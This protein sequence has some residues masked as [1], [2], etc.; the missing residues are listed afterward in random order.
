MPHGQCSRRF[1]DDCGS[2]KFPFKNSNDPLITGCRCQVCCAQLALDQDKCHVVLNKYLRSKTLPDAYVSRF[3]RCAPS[4]PGTRVTVGPIIGRVTPYTARIL[5]EVEFSGPVLLEAV[6]VSLEH[7]PSDDELPTDHRVALA[8]NSTEFQPLVFY[9]NRL[10]PNHKYHVDFS[11]SNP[12]TASVTFRTPPVT[13]S[14]EIRPFNVAWLAGI[15][16]IEER[17]PIMNLDEQETVVSSERVLRGEAKFFTKGLY[18]MAMDACVD[19]VV[20]A[21]NSLRI[22]EKKTNANSYFNKALLIARMT[23]TKPRAFQRCVKLFSKVYRKYLSEASVCGLMANC[24]TL[25]LLGEFDLGRLA[26]EWIELAEVT[27]EEVVDAI[28]TLSS[29]STTPKRDSKT[30]S[31]TPE[32]SSGEEKLLAQ[33]IDRI[34][35]VCAAVEAHNRYFHSLWFNYQPQESVESLLLTREEGLFFATTMGPIGIICLDYMFRSSVLREKKA[36]RTPGE[37]LL[38]SVQW[39]AL[40]K[41]LA[42]MKTVEMLLVHTQQPLVGQDSLYCLPVHEAETVALLNVSCVHVPDAGLR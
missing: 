37:E 10:R 24:P 26:V 15:S 42:S 25:Y 36:D 11:V 22:V 33:E 17:A 23:P 38:G 27:P 1:A 39:R 20:H 3:S 40:N 13:P 14:L 35:V 32:P 5:I 28:V 21:G 8:L 16:S 2:Y 6:G 29:S 19:L 41:K 31:P 7:D 4:A 12:L 34:I 18:H 30:P 9:L